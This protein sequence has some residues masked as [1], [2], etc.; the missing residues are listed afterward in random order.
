MYNDIGTCMTGSMAETWSKAG[1]FGGIFL[2]QRTRVSITRI[3]HHINAI[4]VLFDDLRV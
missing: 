4:T 1:H 3:Y 2:K